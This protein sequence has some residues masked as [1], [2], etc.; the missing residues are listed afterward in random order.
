MAPDKLIT[1][2][3][4]KGLPSHCR[5]HAYLVQSALQAWCV[6]VLANRSFRL[7]PFSPITTQAPNS[8]VAHTRQL[9]KRKAQASREFHARSFSYWDLWPASIIFAT[10]ARIAQNPQP[11]PGDTRPHTALA[12]QQ[13]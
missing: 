5:P 7:N 9:T 8:G 13:E 4:G 10:N 6:L 12:G 2:E 3:E 1:V 11:R